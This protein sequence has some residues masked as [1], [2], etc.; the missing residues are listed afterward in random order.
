MGRGE[1][2]VKKLVLRSVEP[3][4]AQPLRVEENLVRNLERPTASLKD[5]QSAKVLEEVPLARP[6][7]ICLD[8]RLVDKMEALMGQ[9]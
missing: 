1:K 3:K 6:R 5:F 7:V 4:A 9:L 2:S 8:L